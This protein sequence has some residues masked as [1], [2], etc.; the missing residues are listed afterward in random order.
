MKKSIFPMLLFLLIFCSSCGK[1]KADSLSTYGKVHVH[2]TLNG[3]QV[4]Q[5]NASSPLEQDKPVMARITTR[6][7]GNSG[8][9]LHK[10]TLIIGATEF[11]DQKSGKVKSLSISIPEVHE[12][13]TYNLVEKG[14][15]FVYSD[16]S[17]GMEALMG[18]TIAE[19]SDGSC[20]VHITEIGG[21]PIPTAGKIVK[22]SFTATLEDSGTSYTLKGSFNG[23]IAD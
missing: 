22:G 3:T 7:M 1:D 11:I 15:L 16:S 19:S 10:N 9:T 8:E 2:M 5:V 12:P 18:F 23:G 21:E 14:G 20:T 6:D 4:L 17:E 13:G